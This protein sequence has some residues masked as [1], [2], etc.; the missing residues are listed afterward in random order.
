M[1]GRS[2]LTCK[3]NSSS[4][5]RFLKAGT[6]SSISSL[7]RLLSGKEASHPLSKPRSLFVQNLL[8]V[9]S[10]PLFS[11]HYVFPFFLTDLLEVTIYE[12]GCWQYKR[13]RRLHVLLQAVSGHPES[14][15]ERGTPSAGPRAG[16]TSTGR[17][18]QRLHCHTVI[19]TW[20]PKCWQAMNPYME[21]DSVHRGEEG[22]LTG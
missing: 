1:S 4:T 19:E 5:W 18:C 8:T 9:W 20:Q 21:W 13:E 2:R 12:N 11:E 22:K 16:R 3:L 7:D 17:T 10:N 6:S 15:L 14:W